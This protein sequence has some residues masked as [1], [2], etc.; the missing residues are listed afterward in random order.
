MGINIVG[1]VY[2]MPKVGGYCLLG[3]LLYA[4]SRWVLSINIVGEV[5]SVPRVGGY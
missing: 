2:S 5:Y 3:C 1:D 4:R